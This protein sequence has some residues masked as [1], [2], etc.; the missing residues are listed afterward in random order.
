MEIKTTTIIGVSL[1]DLNGGQPGSQFLFAEVVLIDKTSDGITP[2]AYQLK[3]EAV[4][5]NS[6]LSTLSRDVIAIHPNAFMIMGDVLS[7]DKKKKMIYLSN[8]NAVS[9]NHLIVASGKQNSNPSEQCKE[10][11][12]GLQA[13][14]DGLRLKKIPNSVMGV[15][16]PY[17]TRG[18]GKTPKFASID[19]SEPHAAKHIK[20]LVTHRILQEGGYQ[21][22]LSLNGS[23]KRLYEV[24]L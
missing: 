13:L 7:I 22:S 6:D 24:M 8:G 1:R 17:S 14:I 5:G 4:A 18:Q 16:S 9:Y 2:Q 15:T 21:F 10:F 12:D 11:A 23:D 20:D 19:L 3:K